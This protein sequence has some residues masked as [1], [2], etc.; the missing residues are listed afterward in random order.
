MLSLLREWHL[1]H[2]PLPWTSV[3]HRTQT[4][5]EVEE[6][7]FKASTD[8]KVRVV[9]CEERETHDRDMVRGWHLHGYVWARSYIRWAKPKS[10]DGL[11]KMT[12]HRRRDRMARHGCETPSYHMRWDGPLAAGDNWEPVQ[13]RWEVVT[14]VLV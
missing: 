8:V 3:A 6:A 11:C 13:N 2:Y 5:L 7:A 9:Y 12:G 14:L 4:A 10:I 1:L